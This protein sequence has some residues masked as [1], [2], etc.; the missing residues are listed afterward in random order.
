MC[1]ET[2]AAV[3]QGLH[4]IV[5]ATETDRK[6][7]LYTVFRD[8]SPYRMITSVSQRTPLWAQ[9]VKGHASQTR[10]NRGCRLSMQGK[11]AEMHNVETVLTNFYHTV[12]KHNDKKREKKKR[13]KREIPVK[14]LRVLPSKNICGGRENW[15]KQQERKKEETGLLQL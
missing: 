3:A 7:R 6:G 9:G 13:K 1:W 11:C 8:L 12:I 10:Q 15:R 2:K 5:K 14:V 4:S